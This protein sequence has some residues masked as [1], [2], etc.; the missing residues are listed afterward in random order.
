[1][2]NHDE[3]APIAWHR[4]VDIGLDANIDAARGV[5]NGERP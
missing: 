4:T 3:L 2:A 5:G 1:M